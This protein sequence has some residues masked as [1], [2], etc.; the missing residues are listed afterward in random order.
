MSHRTVGDII[1]K[2]PASGVSQL[3]GDGPAGTAALHPSQSLE[4]A[5]AY[6]RDQHVD[7]LPVVEDGGAV[8]TVTQPEV[9]WSL[10]TEA[11]LGPLIRTVSTD[12]SPNDRMFAIGHCMPFYLWV[13]ASAIRC[14][15][16]SMSL[17][18]KQNAARIL[19]FGCGHG[20]V[21]RMLKAVFPD[22]Q[23]T[24]CDV[25]EDGVEFCARAFGATPVLS[26]VDA[27]QVAIEQQFDLIWCGSLFTHLDR[28][29]WNGFLGLI[30]SVL[31]PGG[32]F[33][34]TVQGRHIADTWRA[35]PLQPEHPQQTM[36]GIL[37][38]Y[39]SAGF[40]Y[41]DYA[42]VHNWGDA[43]VTP[44]WVRGAIASTER[45]QLVDHVETEWAAA[46]DVVTC[47]GLDGCAGM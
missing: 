23:L 22:A 19:D 40:G 42:G 9:I 26:R 32:V 47:L 7:K 37:A 5:L 11:E 44:E 1:A 18:G 3:P 35:G 16:R 30:E 43:L 8:G 34:F 15:R 17:L 2:P 21:L 10:E 36:N 39:D 38:D 6:L 14:I 27:T 4:D 13:G 12:V 33:V 29:R 24:A 41:S 31:E 45:L 46:Q 25:L 28:P 20:R